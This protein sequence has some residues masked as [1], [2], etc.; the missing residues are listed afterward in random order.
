MRGEG[1]GPRPGEMGMHQEEN[2]LPE[3]GILINGLTPD[4]LSQAIRENKILLGTKEE[5]TAALQQTGLKLGG[6]SLVNG[7][8]KDAWVFT[9]PYPP[10]GGKYDRRFVEEGGGYQVG[11]I[12]IDSSGNVAQFDAGSNGT[13]DSRGIYKQAGSDDLQGALEEVG[14]NFQNL[15]EGRMFGG[16]DQGEV[17]YGD[18]IKLLSRREGKHVL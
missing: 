11:V 12:F 1:R 6:K 13:V 3:G 2:K 5:V 10:L 8:P 4:Q 14:L 17:G 9:T 18:I 7:R 16:R 15:K